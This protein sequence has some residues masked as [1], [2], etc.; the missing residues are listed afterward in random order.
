M[1]DKC[2]TKIDMYKCNYC[3]RIFKTDNRHKCKFLPELRNCYSCKHCIGIECYD[4]NNG[5]AAL[6]EDFKK[7]VICECGIDINL[8][9][10]SQIRYALNCN[11]WTCLDHYEGK[12]TYINALWSHSNS[13]N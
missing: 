4:H 5:D 11:S 8:R 12:D 2:F 10:L 9:K 3:G 7:K 1:D 13:G 6:D